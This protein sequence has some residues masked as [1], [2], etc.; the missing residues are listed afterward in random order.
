M[1]REPEVLR[2]DIREHLVK[3][4]A[5]TE[6]VLAPTKKLQEKL[7]EEMKARISEVD[8]SVPVVD[9]PYAYY[10]R[11]QKGSEHPIVSR[12]DRADVGS[13]T[14]EGA[15]PASYKEILDAN[16][17]AAGKEFFKL[18]AVEHSPDHALLAYATDVKGSEYFDIRF[19]DVA[20]GVELDDVLINCS[21]SFV[22]SADSKQVIYT[23]IDDNHREKFVYRHTLGSPQSADELIYEEMDDGF[24][25]GVSKTESE[26]FILLC[27]N[28]HSTSEVQ[29]IDAKEPHL[30]P[31]MVQPRIPGV[32]YEVTDH[33]EALL[34]LTNHDGAVDFKIVQTELSTPGA[35]H[36]QDLV[37]H[38]KGRLI[39]SM[40][41]A[42]GLLVRSEKV[43]ALPRLIVSECACVP[44][45]AAAVIASEYMIDFEEEAYS[46]GLHGFDEFS[47]PLLRFTYSSP[48]TPESTIDYD[49]GSRER[50]VRKVQRVP[51]G[52]AAADYVCRRL[53]VPSH[54]GVQVPL[55]VLARSDTLLDGSAPLLLYGYGSYG[56]SMPASFSTAR[57]SVVD[58]GV[59]FAV[60]HVRG[61]ADCGY[62]WYDPYGKTLHSMRVCAGFVHK[63]LTRAQARSCAFG[64]ACVQIKSNT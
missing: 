35:Q 57:L 26:R 33:G 64:Y 5:H 37:P 3:E 22:W 44:T 60:A 36:W 21:S 7:F 10:S 13:W 59:V 27:S 8:S 28:D 39:S 52:H 16:A 49:C 58:R 34:I 46:L 29:L 55:T 62:D 53:M 32:M 20:T 40:T 23:I 45:G 48:T 17:L 2:A 15:A 50:V 4:N 19:R 24:F 9:G 31:V 43:N 25:L 12:I 61:G 54:D 6:Q 42:E 38:K 1:L 56:A 41:N 51:S 14:P 11:Y 30:P 63:M 18:G 47:S